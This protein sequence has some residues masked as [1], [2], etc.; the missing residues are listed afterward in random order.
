MKL[1]NSKG[2]SAYSNMGVKH[3]TM[4]ATIVSVEDGRLLVLDDKTE[5]EVIVKTRCQ[6]FSEGDKVKIIY[7]GIMTLSLPPQISAGRIIKCCDR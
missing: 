7:N 6:N 2:K 4:Y 5:Q 1:G 3:M